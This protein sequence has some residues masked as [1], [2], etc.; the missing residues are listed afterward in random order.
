VKH[1]CDA[2]GH[3]LSRLELDQVYRLVIARADAQKTI[4]DDDLLAVIQQV[5]TLVVGR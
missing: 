1:R 3:T 5:K 4:T 2:L